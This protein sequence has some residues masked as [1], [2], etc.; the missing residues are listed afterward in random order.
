MTCESKY[1]ARLIN[2]SIA[3]R[4][5]ATSSNYMARCSPSRPAKAFPST[6]RRLAATP[7]RLPAP[8]SSEPGGPPTQKWPALI[9]RPHPRPHHPHRHPPLSPLR[10]HRHRVRILMIPRI[11][12]ADGFDISRIIKGGGTWPEVTARLIP[13]PLSVTWP[14]SSSRHHHLRLRQHLYGRRTTLSVTSAATT[15]NMADVSRSSQ[16][17]CRI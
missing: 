13:L 3:A 14:P 12:L 6:T 17:S 16:S 4:N 9:Q 10:C 5:S 1:S 8:H 15:R 7:A 11:T 2:L